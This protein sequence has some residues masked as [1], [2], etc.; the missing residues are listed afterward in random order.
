MSETNTAIT[1]AVTIP[2]V[3]LTYNMSIEDTVKMLQVY[4]KQAEAT[5]AQLQTNIDSATNQLNES[6]R[7]QLMLVGQRQ[8]TKNLL[9]KAIGIQAPV[10]ATAT[11]TTK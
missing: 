8:L 2:D 7:I 4:D 11:A 5:M 10:S 3:P 9:E 6:R 1:G